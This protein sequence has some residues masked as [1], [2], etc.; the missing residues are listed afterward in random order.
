M[1]S[2]LKM[3]NTGGDEI[4][5][6]KVWNHFRRR[7]YYCLITLGVALLLCK[8]FVRYTRPVYVATATIHI[9]EEANPTQG[10]GLLES[11]GNFSSNIQSE[12][13]MLRSRSLMMRALKEMLHSFPTRRS[14]EIGRASWRERV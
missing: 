1:A 5:L 6:T 10:L 11:L 8:L 7:W 13:R 2:G 9:E 14:S 4:N 12:I 3:Q